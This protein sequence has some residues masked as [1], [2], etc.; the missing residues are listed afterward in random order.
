MV[1]A[2]APAKV[3]QNYSVEFG[4]VNMGNVVILGTDSSSANSFVCRRGLGKMGHLE[5]RNLRLRGEVRSGRL[6]VRKIPGNKNSADL[7]TKALPLADIR[8]KL[9]EMNIKLVENR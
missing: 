1:E 3:L 2:V 9:A 7:M 6:E 4:F 5:I 8:E